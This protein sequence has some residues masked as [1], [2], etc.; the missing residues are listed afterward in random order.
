MEY[1]YKIFIPY[2]RGKRTK[3]T[4]LWTSIFFKDSASYFYRKP[5]QIDDKATKDTKNSLKEYRN[6]WNKQFQ[7]M[8]I[9]LDNYDFD[10]LFVAG[11]QFG[12]MYNIARDYNSFNS[13]YDIK[14][15]GIIFTPFAYKHLS[16]DTLSYIAHNVYGHI[17]KADENNIFYSDYDNAD[18][19][20]DTKADMALYPIDYDNVIKEE[21][22]KILKALLEMKELLSSYH[23]GIWA[24]RHPNE[25]NH[26]DRRIREVQFYTLDMYD[27][28][29]NEKST[30]KEVEK[31]VF[32]K[33][34]KKK[35]KKR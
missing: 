29:I 35:R 17:C 27:F 1:T 32:K 28:E 30:S 14:S 6:R 21:R 5:F 9:K 11:I 8:S 19:S 24:K 3:S 25:M 33:K 31:P 7:L 12:D 22:A 34:K 26:L 16:K 23:F 15:I 18:L 4:L 10:H 20:Y 2:A 13:K